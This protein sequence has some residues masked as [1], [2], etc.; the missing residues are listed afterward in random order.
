MIKNISIVT[1]I[2]LICIQLGCEQKKDN[3]H[4]EKGEETDQKIR[5]ETAQKKLIQKYP[6]STILVEELLQWYRDN[7]KYDIAISVADSMTKTNDR[8]KSFHRILAI[9]YYEINDTPN[10]IQHFEKVISN[11]PEIADWLS[12]G[13]LYAGNKNAKA[14][15]VAAY[16]SKTRPETHLKEAHFIR[17]TYYE[18]LQDFNKAIPYFDSCIQLEFSFM[19]AYRE[20]AICLIELKKYKEAIAI[21]D[22]ATI[23]N[24]RFADG[25]FWKGVCFEKLMQSENASMSYQ[26]ALMYDSSYTEAKEALDRLSPK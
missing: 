1:F 10:A 8:N 24:N 17:G 3:F 16:L 13:S 15:S 4:N 20:K 2:F 11:S 21:L 6:D 25:H 19:E 7:N 26:K 9:L 18:A 22:R 5:F 23:L 14:I 12:L